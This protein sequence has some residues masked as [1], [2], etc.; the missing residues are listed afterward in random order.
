M[1]PAPFSVQEIVPFVELAP[2]TVAVALEQMV[3]VPPAVAIGN[4]LTIT[5]YV[6]V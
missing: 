3:C 5:V 6:A 4:G 2:F 1:D